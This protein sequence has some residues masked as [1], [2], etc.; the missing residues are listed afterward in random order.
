[1][2]LVTNMR[3]LTTSVAV[4]AAV[5]GVSAVAAPAMAAPAPTATLTNGTVT[6]TGTTARDVIGIEIGVNQLAIDFGLD[7]TVDAR[8]PV[9]AV[10]Q[11]SVLTGSGDDGV[12]VSGTGVGKVPVA[13]SGGL[14]NDGIGVVGNIGQSGTGDAPVTINGGPGS[15]DIFAAVPGPITINAGTGDDSV[16]GGGAGVGHETISLGDGNDKFVS[17][18][19]AFVG[20]R[21]D[22]VD[23]GTGKDTMEMRGSFASESVSLSASAGHLIVQHNIQDR[24][25]ARNIE[26]VT[27]LGF[28]GLDE[29]GTGDEVSVRDLSGTGVVNFTPDF[30]APQDGTSPN[31][32]A[33]QLT[34]TGTAGADH[35]TVSSLG[36]DITVSGL[37]PSVTP[38]QLDSKDTLRIDTLG[39]NDTVDSSGLRPGLVHLQVF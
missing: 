38:V 26:F 27:W 10:Q 23:G 29:S 36:N 33:D 12:D 25:D 16:E 37:T 11:V 14:G 28:G 24:I 17:D 13:I 34:V 30:S 18:L 31:N 2:K 4:A 20:V 9:S 8:F 19:N 39:G 32:S 35:I 22:V 6:V 21:S 7:G 1:M 5:A 3:R 15:D